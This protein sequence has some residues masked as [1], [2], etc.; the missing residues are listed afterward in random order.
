MFELILLIMMLNIA[1]NVPYGAA[2]IGVGD[3]HSVG[4]VVD[5]MFVAFL[6]IN[7]PFTKIVIFWIAERKSN[8]SFFKFVVSAEADS[9]VQDRCYCLLH[10]ALHDQHHGDTIDDGDIDEEHPLHLDVSMMQPLIRKKS[11]DSH[12]KHHRNSVQ[13][14]AMQSEYLRG[15]FAA[16]RQIL[17]DLHPQKRTYSTDIGVEDVLLT[18]LLL[19]SSAVYLYPVIWA[20]YFSGY[21]NEVFAGN[22]VSIQDL[23]IWNVT[24]LYAMTAMVGMLSMISC[25]LRGL[26]DVMKWKSLLL[27]VWSLDDGAMDCDV[28]DAL[29]LQRTLP[30]VGAVHDAPHLRKDVASIILSYIL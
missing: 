8:G 24:G 27:F 19:L 3:G 16:K 11:T 23:F 4:I 30:I 6:I 7:T 22:A 29:H 1:F 15:D 25:I 5:V 10:S 21:L 26:K 2:V 13:C 9:D 14:L 12:W 28:Y 20:M 17:K 18:V